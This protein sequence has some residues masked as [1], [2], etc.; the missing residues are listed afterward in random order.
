MKKRYLSIFVLMA[1]IMGHALD[2]YSQ[3][4][5]TI[6]SIRRDIPDFYRLM[7]NAKVTVFLS[8]DAAPS[9][10]IT[11]PKDLLDRISTDVQEGW[12]VISHEGNFRQGDSVSIRVG[13]PRLLNIK[14]SGECRLQSEDSLH[15]EGLMMDVSGTSVAVMKFSAIQL[16]IS[17][18][19]NS[20]VYLSGRADGSVIRMEEE[21]FLSG[22]DF[23]I[24]RIEA[25]LAGDSKAYVAAGEELS[26]LLEGNVSLR[27]SGSPDL[28]ITGPSA[29]NAQ[30]LGE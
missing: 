26:A 10:R 3:D 18:S 1:M 4:K 11:G 22:K 30:P 13:V 8:T 6:I 23:E 21:A 7:V 9:L 17:C 20:A 25:R 24:N 29:G 19:G 14:L 28:K 5:D 27:Y 12:L 16:N 15:F 2:T